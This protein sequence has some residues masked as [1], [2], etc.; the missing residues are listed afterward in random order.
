MGQVAGYTVA[1]YLVQHASRERRYERLP[2]S[3]WDAVLSYIRDPADVARLADSA[4]RRLLYRYAIPLYRHAAD[5]GNQSAVSSLVRL[6]TVRGDPDEL[7]TLADAGNRDAAMGLVQVLASRGDLDGAG[8]ILNAIADAGHEAD[9]WRRA[10]C[11]DLD[12]RGDLDELRAQADSGNQNA[13]AELVRLLSERGDPVGAM[14]ALRAWADAGHQS[15]VSQLA[16]LLAK[17]EDRVGLRALAASGDRSAAWRLAQLLAERGDLDGLRAQ[18]DVDNQDAISR[19]AWLLAERGDLEELR[20]LADAGSQSAALDLAGLLAER[21]D[22]DGWAPW[23]SPATGIP[24]G[25]WS[26]CWP[27]RAVARKRSD[28]TGS[29]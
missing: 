8:Q 2:A 12:E 17:C 11:G 28:C 10:K 27:S 9:S 1:D 7:R 15:G 23:P 25:G 26:S 6:L 18:A 13:V 29:A 16:Q 21:G 22:L 5:T 3:T 24:P 19:L 4:E 20:A 14:Q